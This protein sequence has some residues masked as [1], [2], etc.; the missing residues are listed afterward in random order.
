MDWD[1][2]EGNQRDE[3]KDL[4]VSN[5]ANNKP[6]EKFITGGIIKKAR[7]RQME[8]NEGETQK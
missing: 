3:K 8:G 6:K 7:D 5:L 4:E 2:G 1:W